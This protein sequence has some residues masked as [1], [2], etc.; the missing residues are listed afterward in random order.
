[1]GKIKW[2]RF[3][4]YSYLC[5]IGIL[6]SGTIRKE[7]D[8]VEETRT[9]PIAYKAKMEEIKDGVKGP[10]TPSFTLYSKSRFLAETP[11]AIGDEGL[12]AETQAEAEEEGET[13]GED[14][15]WVEEL[16]EEPEGEEIDASGLKE[17][18]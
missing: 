6:H 16:G 15:W 13:G 8:P 11:M 2:V 4:I 5:L 3:V 18:R 10:P 12:E 14:D 1:M 17:K 7:R 9:S